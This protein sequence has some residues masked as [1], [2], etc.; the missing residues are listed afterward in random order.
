MLIWLWGLAYL[1]D[2]HAD[3]ALILPAA[4]AATQDL[5]LA[6]VLITTVLLLSPLL[7]VLLRWRPPF[8]SATILFGIVAGLLCAVTGFRQ[9]VDVVVAVVAGLAADLGIWRYAPSPARPAA[10]RA[11]A[12]VVPIVLWLGHFLATALSGGIAWPPEYWTGISLLAGL[13][14]LGLSV[15]LVPP[16]LPAHMARR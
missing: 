2:G 9:P 5:D 11:L 13:V 15:L 7:L 16:T 4:L 14:G 6:M 10:F 8:G 3:T 1:R 12:L